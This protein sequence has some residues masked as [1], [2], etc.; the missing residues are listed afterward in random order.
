MCIE[1]ERERDFL[2]VQASA[3]L[4]IQ[5]VPHSIWPL[6]HICSSDS[7]KIFLVFVL[8]FNLLDKI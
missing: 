7:Q 4:Q 3:D 2:F 1:R 5:P 8:W 6:I